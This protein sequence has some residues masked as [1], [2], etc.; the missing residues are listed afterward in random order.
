MEVRE[1]A[2][3][4]ELSFEEL[5]GV[6]EQAAGLLQALYAKD[7]TTFDYFRD[8]VP[9]YEL[10]RSQKLEWEVLDGQELAIPESVG[11]RPQMQQA[12]YHNEYH[13]F[14]PILEP[15]QPVLV[16]HKI[17][18]DN[19]GIYAYANNRLARI[20]LYSPTDPFHN[21]PAVIK[22]LAIA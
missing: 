16:A 19:S 3:K 7:E 14:Y 22:K 4:Q 12:E 1:L 11:Q 5:L 2:E 10:F 6:L 18:A 13:W 8:V 21:D 9:I 20:V 15:L 17:E